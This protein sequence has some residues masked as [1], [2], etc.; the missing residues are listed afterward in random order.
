MAGLSKYGVEWWIVKLHPIID[1]IVAA[2]VNGE[3]DEHFWNSVGK[4]VEPD[5][6]GD[7]LGLNGIGNFFPYLNREKNLKL[8]DLG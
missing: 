5:E 8:R 7:Q 1:K 6:S 3:Q 4:V 2:A